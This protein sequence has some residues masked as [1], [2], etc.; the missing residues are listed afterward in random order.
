MRRGLLDTSVV[1][2]LP[3]LDRSTADL[4]DEGVIS[5]ITL[6]ELAV[7]PHLATTEADRAARIA[8]VIDVAHPDVPRG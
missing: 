4:P 5:T 1:L 7:G 3:R 2:L 6:A 8:D